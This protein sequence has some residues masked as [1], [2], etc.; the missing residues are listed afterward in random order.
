MPYIK[1]ERRDD[2]VD[3][4]GRVNPRSIDNAGDLNYAITHLMINYIINKELSY[5]IINDI[6]GVLVN[7]KDEFNRRIIV[8][9]ENKKIESNGDVY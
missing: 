9:Y 3:E 2:I 4:Y 5:Q 8:D 1:Q 7:A 6:V